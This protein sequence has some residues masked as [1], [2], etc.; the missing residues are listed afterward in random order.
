MHCN[1]GTLDRVENIQ[2]AAFML[3]GVSEFGNMC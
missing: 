3:V 1:V 2:C